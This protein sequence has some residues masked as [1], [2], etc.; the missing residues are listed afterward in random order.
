M[1]LRPYSSTH[2]L[3][4]ESAAST[5][6]LSERP[7]GTQRGPPRAQGH[8]E[9]GT[10][11]TPGSESKQVHQ[12]LFLIARVASPSGWIESPPSLSGTPSG[13]F[14]CGGMWSAPPSPYP[15]T[16]LCVVC[17]CVCE[18]ACVCVREHACVCGFVNM[19][20][21]CVHVCVCVCERVCERV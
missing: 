20:V 10:M 14:L 3:L 9:G 21:V 1:L 19:C 7:L 15:S 4:S 17:V 11:E 13:S 12:S 6:H 2:V 16:S 8:G 5:L 18:R